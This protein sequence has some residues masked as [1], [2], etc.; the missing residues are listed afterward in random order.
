MQAS[1]AASRESTPVRDETEKDVVQPTP[2][3]PSREDTQQAPSSTERGRQPSIA[4]RFRSYWPTLKSFSGSH[5]RPV[6]PSIPPRSKADPPPRRAISLPRIPGP[7]PAESS[8]NPAKPGAVSSAVADPN[9]QIT[10]PA[11]AQSQDQPPAPEV[12]SDAETLALPGVPGADENG[13]PPSPIEEEIPSATDDPYVSTVEATT[14]GITST[15]TPPAPSPTE[16]ESLGTSSARPQGFGGL[17]PV[18]PKPST[19]E[20]KELASKSVT[21]TTEKVSK[22]TKE[23][24]ASDPV[25]PAIQPS[26]EAGTSQ[27][28]GEAE[29]SKPPS[30][31]AESSKPS[32]EEKKPDNPET[33]PKAKA[34]SVSTRKQKETPKETPE[35]KELREKAEKAAEELV[36]QEEAEKRKQEAKDAKSK[37]AAAENKEKAREAAAQERK[38][39]EQAAETEQTVAQ[40]RRI[41]AVIPANVPGDQP[42]PPNDDQPWQI[43]QYRPHAEPT[44]TLV[45]E[46]DDSGVKQY[47]LESAYNLDVLG[48]RTYS[49]LV[50]P[51][52]CQNQ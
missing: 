4:Q 22:E 2:E 14:E 32:A 38:T 45:Y 9:V 28:T 25:N 29:A 17:V 39:K 10:A 33:A 41:K 31:E 23:A 20:E 35:Q 1:P 21:T 6:S 46:E 48:T 34:K 37:K 26:V 7:E 50:R 3:T 27:P 8:S 42:P 40:K 30:G 47:E 19:S 43:Y 13:P 52:Q 51:H 18:I 11:A 36:Q 24:T 16:H 5:R 44:T 49:I 12:T 15:E